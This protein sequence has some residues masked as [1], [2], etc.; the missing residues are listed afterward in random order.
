MIQLTPIDLIACNWAI[1]VMLPIFYWLFFGAASK[2]EGI[3]LRF[4][5]TRVRTFITSDSIGLI[6]SLLL[7]ILGQGDIL[8]LFFF[9]ICVTPYVLITTFISKELR[10]AIASHQAKL[11]SEEQRS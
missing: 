5:D 3:G 2:D 4:F 9:P 11:R 8:F 1:A 7:F 10:Y 6:G